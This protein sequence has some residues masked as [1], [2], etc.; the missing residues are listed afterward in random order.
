[1]NKLKGILIALA[2]I[3]GILA[4]S[5]GMGWFDVFYTKTVGKAKQNAEREVFEQTQSY[6]EGKR[7]EAVKF[8]QEYNKAKTPQEKE[9]I[10]E[11]VRLSFANFDEE[12][13][14][15]RLRIFIYNCKYN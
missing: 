11:L 4:F 1:M 7:Q 3:A 8:Y 14:P 13:L 9:A 6:V 2:V 15:E 5:W 12:K 10:K